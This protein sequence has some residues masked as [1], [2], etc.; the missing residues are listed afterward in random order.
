M[1]AADLPIGKMDVA[2]LVADH[3]RSACDQ[4][5]TTAGSALTLQHQHRAIFGLGAAF[6]FRSLDCILI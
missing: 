3:E 1:I 6:G 5:P 4:W 2:I